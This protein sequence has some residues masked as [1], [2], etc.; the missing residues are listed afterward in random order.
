MSLSPYTVT[1]LKLIQ[2]ARHQTLNHSPQSASADLATLNTSPSSVFVPGRNTAACS[3]S[4]LQ[5]LLGRN[6][7]EVVR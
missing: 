6:I 3:L 7:G 5:N 1:R 4:S 2:I